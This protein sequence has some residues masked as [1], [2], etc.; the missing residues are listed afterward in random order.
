[1]DFNNEI[2]E[3][4]SAAAA[5]HVHSNTHNHALVHNPFAWEEDETIEAATEE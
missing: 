2:F 1:M 4:L 3:A 5:E